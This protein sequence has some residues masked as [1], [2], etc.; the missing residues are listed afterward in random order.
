MNTITIIILLM[1]CISAK[2]R[3]GETPQQCLARYGNATGMDE[4]KTT[5]FF[6]K[7]GVDVHV[8]FDGGKCVKISLSKQARDGLLRRDFDEQ[9]VL[10][11]LMANSDGQ[12]WEKSSGL[13]DDVWVTNTR[14]LCANHEGGT[15]RLIIMT[16]AQR[17]K[18][19]QQRQKEQADERAQK[20]TQAAVE[21]A[22]LR[23]F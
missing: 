6:E 1:L 18:E 16:Q 17:L 20:E 15:R 19:L 11:L 13:V 14:D 9:E 22:R 23:G 3:L 12:T 8:T 5:F 4:K 7:N 2:A 21:R 10:I